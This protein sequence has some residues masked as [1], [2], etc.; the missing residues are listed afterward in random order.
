MRRSLH[1]LA[2]ALLFAPAAV[3]AAESDQQFAEKAAHGN[4]LEVELGQLAAE[5]AENGEVKN[6]GQR[7]VEDH[8]QAQEELRMAAEEMGIELPEGIDTKGE[9]MKRK[10]SELSGSDFDR[11]YMDEMVSDHEK[12][13]A[14]YEKFAEQA[15][16]PLQRYA[17]ETLPTLRAHR[18]LAE[19]LHKEVQ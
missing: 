13:V 11:A 15:E 19:Q 4:A 6:F 8:S 3:F 7:L 17:L 5:R 2:A 9:E 10:L 1:W 12:D 14:E 16:S 18:E